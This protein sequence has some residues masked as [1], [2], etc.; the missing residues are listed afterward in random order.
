MLIMEYVGYNY[1]QFQYLMKLLV[2]S[3]VLMF[4]SIY[5]EYD[6]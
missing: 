4:T 5:P 3:G 2:L 1:C 6:T